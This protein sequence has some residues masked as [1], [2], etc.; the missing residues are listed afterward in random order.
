MTATPFLFTVIVARRD[1]LSAGYRALAVSILRGMSYQPR[2]TCQ[3]GEPR[4][5]WQWA[6]TPP[7]LI[8]LTPTPLT[9]GPLLHRINSLF[10][11]P[12]AFRAGQ[13]LFVW[14]VMKK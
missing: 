8:V 2:A 12:A 4:S 3:P 5:V 6:G 11:P 10:V 14:V 7:A 13:C 9:A 1:E